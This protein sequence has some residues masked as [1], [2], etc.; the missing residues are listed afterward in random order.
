M[1]SLDPFIFVHM[2]LQIPPLSLK[3]CLYRHDERF[4]TISLLPSIAQVTTS[5]EDIMSG[6]RWCDHYGTMVITHDQNKNHAVVTFTESSMFKKEK[7][8][9]VVGQI[10]VRDGA[11]G[12]GAP[13]YTFTGKWNT[14]LVCPELGDQV[15]CAP[16]VLFFSSLSHTC[17]YTCFLYHLSSCVA[18]CDAGS[19]RHA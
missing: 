17:T 19:T 11:D 12:N 15:R 7:R 8:R 14:K 9:D 6:N 13:K 3:S 2:C 4:H 5:V 10:Y 18:E 16:L 1:F